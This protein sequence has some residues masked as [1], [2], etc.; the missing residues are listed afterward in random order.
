MALVHGSQIQG[1][2]PSPTAGS[3]RRVQQRLWWESTAGRSISSPS[4]LCLQARVAT[5]AGASPFSPV[6]GIN[7]PIKCALVPCPGAILGATLISFPCSCDY[8]RR[9][10]LQAAVLGSPRTWLL[11]SFACVSQLCPH[12]QHCS[13]KQKG[14]R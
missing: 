8:S 11:L 9:Q 12:R 6:L 1:L 10:L 3:G 2:S 14:A 4:L 7:R 5:A 13:V